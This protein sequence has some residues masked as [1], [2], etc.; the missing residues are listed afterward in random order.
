MDEELPEKPPTPTR[1]EF[2]ALLWERIQDD[3][4]RHHPTMPRYMEMFAKYNG[5]DKPD[6]FDWNR[7]TEIIV[8]IG[9]CEECKKAG[10]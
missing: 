9:E 8:K 6:A 10:K 4:L 5:W 7:D 2:M 3:G 1:V